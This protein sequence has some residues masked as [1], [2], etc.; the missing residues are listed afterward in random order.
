MKNRM[1]MLFL[2][3]PISAYASDMTGVL[4]IYYVMSIVFPLALVHFAAVWIFYKN[5]RYR[6]KKFAFKHTLVAMS[7]P[8]IGIAIML[9]EGYLVRNSSTSHAESFN[10]GILM[11][12]F[13]AFIASIPYLIHL[14][15]STS[16]R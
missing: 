10:T 13:I 14:I 4:T 5:G 15:K 11:Y 6:D 3:V 2:L 16:Q 9:F 12:I 7:V 1:V 8:I